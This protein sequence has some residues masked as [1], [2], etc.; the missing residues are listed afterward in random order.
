MIIASINYLKTNL[1]ISYHLMDGSGI[2]LSVLSFTNVIKYFGNLFHVLR[3]MM[4]RVYCNDVSGL[5]A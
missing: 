2:M 3:L 5:L 1:Q 4:D